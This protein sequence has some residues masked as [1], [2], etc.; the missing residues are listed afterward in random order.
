MIQHYIEYL[1]TGI[2]VSDS[3]SKPI[4]HRDPKKIKEDKN[5]WTFG[6]RFFDRE[7]LHDGATDDILRGKKKNFSPWHY[8]GTPYTKEQVEAK[9]GKDCRASRNMGYNDVERVVET[10][11]GQL[12]P[13][14]KED[15]LL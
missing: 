4:T 11:N 5:G 15:I 1:S 2:I 9:F 7:E 8:W 14:E 12:I 13:M 6:F 3:S 10:K